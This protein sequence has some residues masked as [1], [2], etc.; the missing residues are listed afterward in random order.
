MSCLL[1]QATEGHSPQNTPYYNRSSKGSSR[2]I[3]QHQIQVSPVC[4]TYT[5]TTDRFYSLPHR[6]Y[7]CSLA[8]HWEGT[9]WIYRT[10]RWVLFS[11]PFSVL[12]RCRVYFQLFFF[13]WDC[14]GIG[15]VYS[16]P[17]KCRREA[18]KSSAGYESSSV[19]R[20]LSFAFGGT[21]RFS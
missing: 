12:L 1:I 9:P 16:A 11:F 3:S 6:F 2:N 15:E 4:D 14:F 8:D 17:L 5:E 7:R 13:F 10:W 18:R 21:N 19:A 20:L